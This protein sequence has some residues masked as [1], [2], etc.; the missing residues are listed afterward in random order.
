MGSLNRYPIEEAQVKKLV[1][2]LDALRVESF[3]VP[4]AAPAGGTVR[5][6]VETWEARPTCN[7]QMFTD[8]CDCYFTEGERGC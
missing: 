4:D 5:A 2:R 1:L 6:H 7:T 8:A 3:E